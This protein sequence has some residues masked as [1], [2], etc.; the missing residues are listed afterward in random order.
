M[1]KI[2]KLFDDPWQ[3]A[4]AA[5]GLA[6]AGFYVFYARKHLFGNK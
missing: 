3:I 2:K 1:D 6:L 4:V 5:S